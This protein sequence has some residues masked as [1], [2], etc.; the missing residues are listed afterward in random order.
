MK[1]PAMK[2]KR[3]EKGGW[4]VRK[5]MFLWILER[6]VETDSDG[7]N[8]EGKSSRSTMSCQPVSPTL[9][10][11]QVVQHN[12]VA[13]SIHDYQLS[14]SVNEPRAA[15]FSETL[16]SSRIPS[17]IETS[18]PVDSMEPSLQE[19]ALPPPPTSPMLLP[20]P[21]MEMRGQQSSEPATPIS[22]GRR[23]LGRIEEGLMRLIAPKRNDPSEQGAGGIEGTVSDEISVVDSLLIV[24]I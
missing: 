10:L 14:F 20:D 3:T 6:G 8:M 5:E 18:N 15:T 2:K 9:R 12:T 17:S 16:E 4:N 19:F 11:V 13:V 1:E 24:S 22:R 23:L 7:R 21:S